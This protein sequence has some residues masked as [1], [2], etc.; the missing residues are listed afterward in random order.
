MSLEVSK[1]PLIR[2]CLV[3]WYPDYAQ[4]TSWG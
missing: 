3:I 1:L 2:T 4:I